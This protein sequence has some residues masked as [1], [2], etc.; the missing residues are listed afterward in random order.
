VTAAKGG[1]PTYGIAASRPPQAWMSGRSL[2]KQRGGLGITSEGRFGP[3]ADC[4]SFD[5]DA[6]IDAL[7]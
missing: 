7:M 5:I 2:H 6:A 4:P 1:K 3:E